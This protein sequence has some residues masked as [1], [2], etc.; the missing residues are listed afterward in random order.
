MSVCFVDPTAI[1]TLIA[2]YKDFKSRGLLFCIA[3]CSGKRITQKRLHVSI[4]IDVQFVVFCV[5]TICSLVG[6]YRRVQKN[7]LPS[8]L[9]FQWFSRYIDMEGGYSECWGGGAGVEEG[10]LSDEMKLLEAVILNCRRVGEFR[11]LS[12]SITSE[13]ARIVSQCC[14][15]GRNCMAIRK[16]YLVSSRGAN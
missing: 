14:I 7:T 4:V 1:K 9:M 15:R 8:V 2:M 13:Q 10:P 5:V 12:T 16:K 6:V 11:T 3:D